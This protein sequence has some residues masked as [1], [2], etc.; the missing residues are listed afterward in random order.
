[1]NEEAITAIKCC[2]S[3]LS[4]IGLIDHK[5]RNPIHEAIKW[6]EKM[7]ALDYEINAKA[8]ARTDDE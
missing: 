2:R 4:R 8:D 6:I 7:A 3:E 1:M 5:T